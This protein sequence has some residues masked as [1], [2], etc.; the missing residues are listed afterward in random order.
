M[1]SPDD[2]PDP[3]QILDAPE[4]EHAAA[5]HPA[6]PHASHVPHAPHSE[7]LSLETLPPY[8][9][10]LLRIKVPVVVTLARKKQTVSKILEIGPGTILQ[11]TKP[12]DQLLEL[13][14]NGH[15]VGAGEAVKVGDKFGM[16]VVTMKLPDERFAAVKPRQAS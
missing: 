9:R 12:C 2:R 5:Q 6:A 8:A 11:F 7:H 3:S 4:M 14:V 1:S 16:R 15:E 13:E 10:S